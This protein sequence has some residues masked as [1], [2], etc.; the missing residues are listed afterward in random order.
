MDSVDIMMVTVDTIKSTS[1]YFQNMNNAV[2]I[3][4]LENTLD[5]MVEHRDTA[6]DIQSILS[7][8]NAF[9]EN[10]FDD[11]DLLKE[12][13]EMSKE[14]DETST[15]TPDPQHTANAMSQSCV[16]V[17][18]LPHAPTHTLPR[19]FDMSSSVPNLPTIYERKGEEEMS[20]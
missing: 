7:D 6:T 20:L 18:N 12:L 8:I 11:A 16:D 19:R 9:S 5:E 4:K 14:E 17:S 10:N 3:S 15:T 2:N 1:D 13:E